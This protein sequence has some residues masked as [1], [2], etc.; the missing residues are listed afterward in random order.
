VSP[1]PR[2][3]NFRMPFGRHRGGLLGDVPSSYL[4]WA[5]QNCDLGPALKAAIGR[6]LGLEGTSPPQ[7]ENLK[8]IIGEW[9]RGLCRDMHPDR[10][11]SHE[12]MVGAMEAYDRLR[13]LLGM[14]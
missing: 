12:K 3:C 14:E 10:G 7:A 5:W 13:V 9:Y 4:E 8:R 6:E 2:P 1:C 11:G